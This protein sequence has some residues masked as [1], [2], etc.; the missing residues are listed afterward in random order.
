MPT[1]TGSLATYVAVSTKYS[2]VVNV[3]GYNH[4]T[5]RQVYIVKAAGLFSGSI[6]IWLHHIPYVP[7][8]AGFVAALASQSSDIMSVKP[9]N[10]SLSTCVCFYVCKR[11]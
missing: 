11:F 7:F 4:V 1:C 10:A 2:R 9:T 3:R 5:R 8:A 6:V